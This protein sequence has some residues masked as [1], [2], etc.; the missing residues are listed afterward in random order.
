MRSGGRCV[1]SEQSLLEERLRAL[2]T[3]VTIDMAR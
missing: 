3:Q 1:R 2:D